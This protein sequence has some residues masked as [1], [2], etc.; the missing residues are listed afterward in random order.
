[1]DHKRTAAEPDTT[2]YDMLRETRRLALARIAEEEEIKVEDALRQ[3]TRLLVEAANQGKAA[4]T[5]DCRAEAGDD[6]DGTRRVLYQLTKKQ[7]LIIQ[8]RLR[9]Q[10]LKVA[11]DVNYRDTRAWVSWE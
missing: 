2:L 11:P 7:F 6:A 9:A 4:Y 1:M 3:I 10:G 8:E 5:I